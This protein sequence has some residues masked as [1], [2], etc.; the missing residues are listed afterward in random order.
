MSAKNIEEYQ[1]A[2]AITGCPVR[3]AE[4]DCL[5]SVAFISHLVEKKGFIAL[6]GLEP[7]VSA[8]R[9]RRVNQLHHSAKG[10]AIINV[11]LLND[12]RG[13]PSSAGLRGWKA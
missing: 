3:Y 12:K 7:A 9:G 6:A 13:E 10:E 2:Q 8:L 5:A 1:L 11:D 4:E